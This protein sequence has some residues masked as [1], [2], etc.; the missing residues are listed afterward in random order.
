MTRFIA[1]TCLL[2]LLACEDETALSSTEPISPSP[3]AA[4]ASKEILTR[5]QPEITTTPQAVGK[6]IELGGKL[7]HGPLTVETRFEDGKVYC[8]YKRRVYGERDESGVVTLASKTDIGGGF[9][10]SHDRD[11][12]WFIYVHTT[13]EIWA[14]GGRGWLSRE[15]FRFTP[16]GIPASKCERLTIGDRWMP[17][18]ELLA[19]MPQPLIDKINEIVKQGG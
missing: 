13:H 11:A 3:P 15:T 16:E 5:D 18:A 19:S 9:E 12:P 14:Y 10:F 2:A 17:S 4:T 1:C 7:Q 6:F 8:D